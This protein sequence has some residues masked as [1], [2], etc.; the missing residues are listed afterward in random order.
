MNPNAARHSGLGSPIGAAVGSTVGN[1]L[2]FKLSLPAASRIN[3]FEYNTP[4]GYPS[5]ALDDTPALPPSV[6]EPAPLRSVT[7]FLF[8]VQ[9]MFTSKFQ[10][11]VLSTL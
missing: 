9:F 8:F 11:L 5:T 10:S 4:K 1:P 2:A 6:I 3:L 7:K